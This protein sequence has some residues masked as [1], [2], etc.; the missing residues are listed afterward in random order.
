MRPAYIS[1]LVAVIIVSPQTIFGVTVTLSPSA[2]HQTILGWGA[3]A[4]NVS[5]PKMLRDQILD[6]AVNDLGLTRLRFEIPRRDWE[7]AVNDNSDPNT[8]NWSAFKTTKTDFKVRNWIQPFK[9]RVEANGDS[10]NLYV[11]PSFFDSRSSGTVPAW[12]LNSPAEYAECAAAFLTYLKKTYNIT[13][14]Y[15][16]ICNEAGN[17]NAFS[18]DV[19]SNMIKALG[20]KMKALGLPTKIEFPE[21]VNA[22]ESWSYIQSTQNDAEMWRYVGVVT[23]HL[24]GGNDS[25]PSIR[26]FALSRGLPTGQTEYMNTT[27]NDLYNDLTLGGVSYWEH[28]VLA[29]YGSTAGRADYFGANYNN[30]SFT[31]YSDYWNFRQI[32]RYVR[33]G[34]VRIDATSDDTALRPLAFVK[35]RKTV[36]VLLNNTAP[37]QARSVTVNGLPRGTYGVCRSIAGAAYQEVG[38]QRVG[39]GGTLTT[40]VPS[41]SVMT[42]YPYSGANLPPRVTNWAAT[43]NYLEK[44]SSSTTLSVSA[45][46]PENEALSY[47]WSIAGKPSG[48]KVSLASPSSVSCSASGLTAVGDYVFNIAVRDASHTVNRSVKITVFS[49]NQPPVID[50]SHNRLPVTVTLPTTGTTLRC[51]VR[52]LEGDTLTY[53]WSVV[54]QPA[55]ASVSLANNTTT[56]C[57][58]SN[59]TV[60]GN[61]V[62]KAQVADPLGATDPSHIVSESLTVAVYPAGY[63]GYQRLDGVDR[64]Q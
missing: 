62:F 20:P 19:V 60:A 10:F 37:S 52:D 46:D 9:R 24:Y 6:E 18:A 59:M 7:D 58:A 55:G 11:S 26:D 21:C 50:S 32:M 23:Y 56:S 35:D 38:L 48:A 54:S 44:P 49:G 3:T 33:P 43:P 28:Y 4:P 14:D 34:A 40:T 63:A 29:Y 47:T 41:N 17:G 2:H 39:S 64:K 53:L 45:T 36:V 57:K 30:T 27:V 16:C 12:M 31:R 5:I 42:I 13:A 22:D 61:Y 15:Y 8:V 51:S 1:I 25:R